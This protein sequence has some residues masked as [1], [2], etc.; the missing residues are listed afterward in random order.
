MISS[1][2]PQLIAAGANGLTIT[3]NGSNFPYNAVVVANST[4]LNTTYA[5]PSQLIATVPAQLLA[6]P[7]I[8]QIVVEAQST[9]SNAVPLTV[10]PDVVLTSLTPALAVAQSGPTMITATGANFTATTELVFNGAPLAT[11]MVS[12]TQLQAVIPLAN[13]ATAQTVQV[14]AFDP[15]SQSLSGSVGFTILPGPSVVFSAPPTA[16]PATQPTVTFQLSQ[17]YPIPLAG[18]MTLTFL[19]SPGEPDDPAIQFASGGR[20]LNF[21]VPANSTTTPAVQLQAGTVAGSITVTLNLTASGVNV[22]PQSA[23]PA[24]IVVPK[25]IP[26]ITNQSLVRN[27]SAV[28]IYV[29]GYSSSRDMTNAYFSFTPATGTTFTETDFTVPVTSLFSGWFGSSTS[30]Q[31]GSTF[32]YFQ[33]FNLSTDAAYVDSVSVTLENAQ[34]KSQPEVVK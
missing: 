23:V 29:T 7:S 1:I 3:V 27:G 32:T 26:V 9:Q 34:G 19:P 22:T 6:T 13:L 28:T 12:T 11:T 5:G 33:T 30:N 4:T 17:P 21:T 25:S 2:S 18:T 31:Y 10:V 16:T 20:T 14:T 24:V 15:A 8:I